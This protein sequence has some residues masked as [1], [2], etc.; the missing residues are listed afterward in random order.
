MPP[1]PDTSKCP[2][3]VQILVAM[4]V[5][6]LTYLRVHAGIAG[7]P[8]IKAV[9]ITVVHAEGRRD[10]YRIVNL[11]VGRALTPRSLS[12]FRSYELAIALHFLPAPK[13][14]RCLQFRSVSFEIGLHA[15]HRIVSGHMTGWNRHAAGSGKNSSR[16][17]KKRRSE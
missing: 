1:A 5:Q 4:L 14:K 3:V 17:T 2:I 11:E 6:M 12:F 13:R 7:L 8:A 10:E 9:H 16:F 15:L